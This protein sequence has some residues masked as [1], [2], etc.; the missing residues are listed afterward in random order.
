MPSENEKQKLEAILHALAADVTTT[1]YV[2]IPGEPWSKQRPR[3]TKKGNYSST[4]QPVED[5]QAEVN[6]AIYIRQAIRTPHA[7]NVALA[8]IFYQSNR[9][10][11]DY[12]NMLKHIGDAGNTYGWIDDHQITAGAAIIELDTTNPRTILAIANHTTTLKR[13]TNNNAQCPTCQQYFSLENKPPTQQYCTIGCAKRK[14][15][16]TP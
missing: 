9:K 8:A 11:H 4:Y 14:R 2:T 1:T 16:D 10:A 13:G 6:T 12:D 7:G 5:K 3:F 15:K